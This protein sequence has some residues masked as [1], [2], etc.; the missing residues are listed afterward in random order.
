MAIPF[1]II[2]SLNWEVEAVA[3]NPHSR[4]VCSC[5]LTGKM[6]PLVLPLATTLVIQQSPPIGSFWW[7]LLLY[8]GTSLLHKQ[9]SEITWETRELQSFTFRLSFFFK[10]WGVLRWFLHRLCGV[11]QSIFNPQGMC[12]NVLCFVSRKETS[13]TSADRRPKQFAIFTFPYNLS[14]REQ[15][16]TKNISRIEPC[17]E[18]WKFFSL[19]RPHNVGRLGK[20]ENFGV[21]TFLDKPIC[22]TICLRDEVISVK[23]LFQHFFC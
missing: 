3:K 10:L 16:S 19:L 18:Y 21:Q 7:K 13:V 4:N 11:L 23:F 8:F 12:F 20:D 1:L 2:N 6:D 22:C 9:C 17:S 14:S 5:T 15:P